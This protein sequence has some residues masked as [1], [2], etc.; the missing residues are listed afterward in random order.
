VSGVA[1][2][3]K[4]TVA[5][6]FADRLDAVVV[7]SDRVRKRL[8]AVAPTERLA[9][10]WERGAYTPE[11]TERVY[12]GL[13]ERAR[14]VLE[15]G[16]TAILDATFSKRAQRDSAFRLAAEIGCPAF[17][18]EAQCDP[19]VARER[20]ARRKEAGTDPSD[21]G[22]ESYAPSARG[23]EPPEEW[24]AS[25]RARVATDG[26]SWEAALGPITDRIR[27]GG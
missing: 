17:L 13:F 6:R 16:R 15:S 24:P 27:D 2:T 20:M 3:G 18:V 25:R 23:F 14:P 8:F 4:S 12:E 10:A 22:P 11:H 9:D 19:D 1:G 7:A 21:A 5:A 26:E